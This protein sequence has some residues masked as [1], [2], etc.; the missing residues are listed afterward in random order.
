[1]VYL[2][3]VSVLPSVCPGK[4]YGFRGLGLGLDNSGNY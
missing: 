2:S 4:Q 3:V 1:M